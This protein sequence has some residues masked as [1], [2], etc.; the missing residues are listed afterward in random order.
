MQTF[1]DDL[2]QRGV[3]DALAVLNNKNELLLTIGST[4]FDKF[5]NENTIRACSNKL[6]TQIFND[7]TLSAVTYA[8]DV[9]SNGVPV[10]CV[11]Y[12]KNL[13]WLK[14]KY[15]E[16]TSS[17]LQIDNSQHSGTIIPFNFTEL[18]VSRFNEDIKYVSVT[19]LDSSTQDDQLQLFSVT[20][21]TQFVD[22]SLYQKYRDLVLLT[23]FLI[24]LSFI[25]TLLMSK[26]FSKLNVA[27]LRLQAPLKGVCIEIIHIILIMKLVEL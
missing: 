13:N 6:N 9:F 17:Y 27:I 7:E 16:D 11:V 10:G 14:D 8:F 25:L 5:F 20:N 21:M 12:S 18:L 1:F 26:E 3:I 24:T 2:N 23:F 15:Y 19:E 4:R 22:Q